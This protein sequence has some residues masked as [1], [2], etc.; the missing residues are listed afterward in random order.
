VPIIIIIAFSFYGYLAYRVQPSYTVSKVYSQ[1][2]TEDNFPVTWP[3]SGAAAIGYIESGSQA[4]A[5]N[6]GNK[7]RPSASTIKVLTASVVLAKKPLAKGADGE[8]IYFT[9][10]DVERTNEIAAAGGVY[11]PITEGMSMTYKQAL[12]ASLV[13][14]ANNITEKLAT[15]AYGT[16]PDYQAAAH[17]YMETYGINDTVVSDASGLL[18]TTTTTADDLLK[19]SIL[20]LKV[21]VI[22]EV[23]AI[24]KTQ[25]NGIDIVNTNTLLNSNG[26]NGMKTGYTPEAGNCLI[27]STSDITGLTDYTFIAVVL[28][29]PDRDTA[30]AEASRLV[31]VVNDNIAKS[32]VTARNDRV[33]DVESS[34]G[35]VTTGVAKNDLT[36][37]KW[38]GE[39]VD[40]K[41]VL[42][43]ITVSTKGEKIGTVT[44]RDQSIDVVLGNNLPV[45][46]LWW[47]LTHA[48]DAIGQMI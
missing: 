35:A 13:S 20:A 48:F 23:V 6:D 17:Q 7:K 21:P 3:A 18:P 28:S 25:I 26:V 15:W 31:R 34:W 11:Y 24:V 16:I 46:S 27:L 22:K 39:S 12:E 5:S 29:Q 9:A 2:I 32:T 33:A 47:R 37:N 40:A 19:I 14:S 42:P 44:L 10:A 43:D 36:V 30:N 45:P 8:R 4:L 41:V 38:K 1:R